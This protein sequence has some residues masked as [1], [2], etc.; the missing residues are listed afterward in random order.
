MQKVFLTAL[1]FT[2]SQS[3]PSTGKTDNSFCIS[4]HSCC[5]SSSELTITGFI[6]NSCSEDGICTGGARCVVWHS[7]DLNSLSRNG[8]W[9]YS[10]AINLFS[11]GHEA[12]TGSAT[13]WIEGSLFLF[14]RYTRHMSS[15]PNVAPNTVVMTAVKGPR[16]DMLTCSD[17]QLA[18]ERKPWAKKHTS[19]V[20]LQWPHQALNGTFVNKKKVTFYLSCVSGN[21][22]KPG[23]VP[24]IWTGTASLWKKK[25][26]HHRPSIHKQAWTF[27][28]YLCLILSNCKTC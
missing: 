12:S 8:G 26:Q 25:R 10:T 19:P 27:K 16:W 18:K 22:W 1:V 13:F 21:P 24:V 5:H 23:S 7:T 17:L 15:P 2:H 20:G 3:R 9:L 6:P 4:G 11:T 14:V 28:L